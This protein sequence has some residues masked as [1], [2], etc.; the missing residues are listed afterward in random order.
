MLSTVKHA[1]G[2]FPKRLYVITA[3]IFLF[4]EYQIFYQIFFSSTR[5]KSSLPSATQKTLGKKK[6]LCEE[7]LCRVLP[8]F[9][10]KTLGK[11]AI[12]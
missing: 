1:N 5:Q 4:A 7:A 12:C 9:K 2:D 3:E 10:N 11:R 8:N 6:T